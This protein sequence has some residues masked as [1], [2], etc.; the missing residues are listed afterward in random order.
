M[1]GNRLVVSFFVLSALAGA[2]PPSGAQSNPERAGEI[3]ALVPTDYVLRGSASAAQA[4]RNDPVYWQDTVRTEAGGRVRIGLLDGSILNVGSQ[5]SLLIAKHDP[6]TQQTQL[7]LQYGRVRANVVRIA[8]PRGNFELRTPVAV[9]GV[10][11]TGFD[12]YTTSDSTG[13]V[14]RENTVRVRNADDGVPGEVILHAGEF[15]RVLRGQPPTP[16]APASPEQLREGEEATSIAAE[17]GNW[18]RVEISWPP[19]NCGQEFTLLVRAWSKQV[20]GNQ[21]VETPVDPELV[22]GKLLLGDAT[23]AVEGG[24]ANLAGA[25][26]SEIPKGAFVPQGQGSAIPTKIWPPLKAAPGEGWHGPRAMFTGSAFY[27][28]GP[29]GSAAR[30]EF[31]FADQPATLLWAGACGA[32]FLA[33]AIPGGAYHVTLSVGSEP[34]ARG[35]MNLIQISYHL[36]T[37]PS[38]LRGQETRL[39]IEMRGLAGLDRFVQ[40]RPIVVT[41]VTNHTPAIIGNLR[42]QTPGASTS[43][44]TITYRVA[45]QNV[46]AS[47][48]AR[49]EASARG[50]QAGE[51]ELG[52]ENKL[53]EALDLPNTPLAAARP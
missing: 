13:V 27:I 5:S 31:A 33:P 32:G 49:L 52:V 9:T 30:V 34:V 7:E 46:D 15:T 41:A 43:G 45:G 25:Q 21:E 44:E 17:V 48:T 14:C 42:T 4:K 19:P 24:R 23:V 47:G 2:V 18:S 53:D 51:F 16:A 12:V 10:V 40:G 22:T 35:E 29:V 20:Q 1:T 6:T 8:K 28:L 50:R 38:V 26:G 11:G 3:R 39:S 36:P 37:P